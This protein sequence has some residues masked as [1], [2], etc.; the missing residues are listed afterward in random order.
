MRR[1]A[2]ATVGGPFI[3]VTME[4]PGIVRNHFAVGSI[5]FS[6]ALH[7]MPLSLGRSRLLFR[8]ISKGL[9]RRLVDRKPKWLRHLNSCKVLEQD[10]GLITTQNDHFARNPGRKLADDFIL[11]SSSDKFVGAYRRWLDGV[12]HGMPWFQGLVSSSSNIHADTFSATRLLP[13]GLDPA[14]HAASGQDIVETRYH[15]HVMHCP[16][17]RNA[18]RN[19]KRM[20][21]T[22]VTATVLAVTAA[23]GLAP[24]VAASGVSCAGGG[25]MLACRTIL[26]CLLL[27]AVPLCAAAATAAHQ[28]EQR[29]YVSFKRK[30]QLRT[31]KG[32]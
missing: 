8:T 32:V 29:F 26:R 27:P 28:L 25:P 7:C 4:A 21:R 9:P 10:V 30:D 20:K 11:L 1:A 15:R 2:S 16:E 14:R 24:V 12:G 13:P 23:L 31:E 5:V 19:V 3:N 22:F 6:A 17:T 18:L